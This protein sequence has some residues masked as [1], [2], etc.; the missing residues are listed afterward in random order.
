MIP[1]LPGP[2]RDQ[3]P[4]RVLV[5]DEDPRV[6][7]LLTFAL[8]ANHFRVTSAA[9]GEAALERA[10][11]ERPDLVVLSVR[12]GRR[13]GLELCELLRREPE[14]GDVPILL[15]SAT[16]DTQARIEALAHGADDFMSKPFSP[17][18]LVARAQRLLARARDAARHR[19]RNGELE[20]DLGRL[21]SEAAR[22]REEAHRERTLRGLGHHMAGELLRTLDLDALEARLLR[23]ACR[24]TGARSAALLA[25]RLHDGAPAAEAGAFELRAVRGDVTERYAG[26]A[27]AAHGDVAEWL[28]ALDRPLHRD[29]LARLPETPRELRVLATHGVALVAALR[30]PVGVEAMVVCED[31]PD[32]AAFSRSDREHLYALCAAAAPARAMALRF[33]EHQDRALGLLSAPAAREPRRR[34]AADESLARLL[35]VARELDVTGSELQ[36]LERALELGPWCWSEDG[37]AA[38]GAFASSDPT[39]RVQRLC[40]LLARAHGCAAQEPDAGEDALALLTAAGLRYQTLRLSGRSPYEAWRTAASWLGMH[41]DPVLRARFPEA[42]EP[43]R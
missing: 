17:K 26:L 4:P 35:A 27:L 36:L 25:P 21:Q 32:G 13:G 14:H 23:E 7:E 19:A 38:L 29:E 12:L 2:P 28:H 18:E 16:N 24:L 6:V 34:A 9:D 11:E 42:T 15:L 10:R 33:R 43:V 31:R 39:R 1:R 20:R 22:A 5:A 8:T 40:D 41:A 3:A 37:R 30:G